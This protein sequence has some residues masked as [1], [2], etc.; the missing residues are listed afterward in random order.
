[1]LFTF[2]PKVTPGI[3]EKKSKKEETLHLREEPRGAEDGKGK[4]ADVRSER[5]RVES[6]KG[7][8][9]HGGGWKREGRFIRGT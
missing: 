5:G 3:K 7:F 6:G 4:R 8:A 1:V 9:P 2:L